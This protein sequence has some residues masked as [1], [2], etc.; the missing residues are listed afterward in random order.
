MSV[1]AVPLLFIARKKEGMFW[2]HWAL[3]GVIISPM[4][5]QAILGARR[6][7]LILV[8]M[9]LIGGY[10]GIL[11]KKIPIVLAAVSVILVGYVALFLVSNR[12]AIYVGSKAEFSR[13][14]FE[15]I[16]DLYGS[17]YVYG[18]SIMRYLLG[19]GDPFMGR[20]LFGHILAR[21]IP[22]A[23][24]PTKYEEVA[25]YLNL[26]GVD[27]H[28]NNGVPIGLVGRMTGWMPA[29]GAAPGFVAEVCLE[30]GL[31]APVFA[32]SIGYFFAS[33]WIAARRESMFSNA[34]YLLMAS[35]SVYLVLQSLE[36]FTYRIIL[37]GI[38][39][40]LISRMVSS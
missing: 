13:G 15:A 21:V 30:F 32:F 28:V 40:L 6:G 37:F 4:L 5:L 35:M 11:R 10:V 17:E 27:F 20:R 8:F 25:S 12:D 3:L 18:N 2:R 39:T 19:G 16:K 34:V 22:S 23:W 24:W 14:A 9:L 26:I 7:P 33:A 31:A 36:A 38:P 29:V 1:V